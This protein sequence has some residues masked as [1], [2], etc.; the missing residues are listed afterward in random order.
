[1]KMKSKVPVQKGKIEP[2]PGVMAFET[3]NQKVNQDNRAMEK[4]RSGQ[5]TEKMMTPK[6]KK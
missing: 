4:R 3:F 6:K 1:M 2:N 5:M